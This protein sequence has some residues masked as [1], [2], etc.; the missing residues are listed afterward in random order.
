MSEFDRSAGWVSQDVF[1]QVKW[2]RDTAIAQLNEIG[3]GFGEKMDNYQQIIHSKWTDMGDFWQCGNCKVTRLKH[4][5]SYYGNTIASSP[6]D[7][8][9]ACGAKMDGINEVPKCN[10]CGKRLDKLDLQEKFG[11]D[12]H[13]GYGSKYDLMHLKASFCCDCFDKLIDEIKEKA[14]INPV[15]GV[16][17]E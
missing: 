14:I 13:V 7:F 4:F 17:D 6:G 2:E 15:V 10:V 3:A 9:S 11:F 5:K 12:Y 1:D 8:C 16:D